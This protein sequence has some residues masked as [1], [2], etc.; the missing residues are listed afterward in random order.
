MNEQKLLQD[1]LNGFPESSHPLDRQR[2]LNY[3]I[4]CAR[5]GNYIDSSALLCHGVSKE[6]VEKY[7]I[8]FE[9]IRDTYNAINQ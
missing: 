2:F 7:E 3:A 6:C 5:N 9:W 8:A 4:E 1:F